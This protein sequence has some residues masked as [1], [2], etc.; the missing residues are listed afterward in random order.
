MLHAFVIVIQIGSFKKKILD[1][2]VLITFYKKNAVSN[3][4]TW[5]VF[6]MEKTV[7]LIRESPEVNSEVICIFRCER[8]KWHFICTK[9]SKFIGRLFLSQ[10]GPFFLFKVN[11]GC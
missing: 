6:E 8:L 2:Q 9:S 10:N 3:F 4:H 7:F 1:I 5:K 11:W